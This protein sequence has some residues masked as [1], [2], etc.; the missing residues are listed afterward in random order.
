MHKTLPDLNSRTALQQ[1]QLKQMGTCFKA[2]TRLHTVCLTQSKSKPRTMLFEAFSGTNLA[3]SVRQ[4][5]SAPSEVGE[6]SR[7]RV[8]GVNNYAVVF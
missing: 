2:Y 6:E 5:V 4:N 3:V 7:P 8:K 1:S